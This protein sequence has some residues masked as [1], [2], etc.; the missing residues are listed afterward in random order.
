MVSFEGV[1]EG[2]PAQPAAGAGSV[3]RR[4]RH[5]QSSRTSTSSSVQIATLYLEDDD[6]LNAETY[7][8]TRPSVLGVQGSS[9]PHQDPPA[10]QKSAPTGFSGP[11]IIDDL[12]TPSATR[13]TP[14]LGR[15]R[16]SNFV[17]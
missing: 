8:K 7:I 12:T 4:Q 5:R 6:A 10:S 15:E 3:W 13:R 1:D 11:M 16:R 2:S 9:S 14:R 17:A